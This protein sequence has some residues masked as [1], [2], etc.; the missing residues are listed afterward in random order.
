MISQSFRFSESD[1]FPVYHRHNFG[2]HESKLHQ[3]LFQLHRHR[4]PAQP[5]VLLPGK[6]IQ[7]Q[8]LLA[9]SHNA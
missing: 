6:Q 5:L 9:R 8:L 4:I 7:R 1:V 2:N 3:Y